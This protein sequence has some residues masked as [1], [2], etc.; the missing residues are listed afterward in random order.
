MNSLSANY[1]YLETL[2]YVNIDHASA[3]E[4]FNDIC[5]K[6]QLYRIPNTF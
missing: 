1:A 4:D 6:Y 2:F 3:N 5:T